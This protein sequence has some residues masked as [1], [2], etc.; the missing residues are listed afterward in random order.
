MRKILRYAAIG[1]LALI[2]VAAGVALGAFQL[3]QHKLAA[4]LQSPHLGFHAEPAVD[5]VYRT[6]DGAPQHLSSAIGKVVFLD[7]WGTWCVQCVAEMPTVQQLRDHYRNDP[8][9]TFLIVSRMDSASAVR[10]YARRNRLD[11][12]FFLTRDE[13]IP[14]SMQLNQ[15]PATFL[16]AKDGSLVA[17]HVGAAD[18]SDPSVYKFI[19]ALKQ[20]ET[21]QR[22]SAPVDQHSAARLILSSRP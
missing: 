21:T 5:L 12:P 15:F 18:W 7:L 16:Y 19:D 10:A 20:Q 8:S 3:V 4:R 22:A 9:V 11:L 17:K 2:V 13:D 1:V 6:L 14:P